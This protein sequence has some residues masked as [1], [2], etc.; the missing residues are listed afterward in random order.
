[1]QF[2]TNGRISDRTNSKIMIDIE[3]VSEFAR[4]AV[5]NSRHSEKVYINGMPWKILAQIKTK[6]ESTENNE[7]WLAIYLLYDGPKEDLNWRCCVRSATFRIVLQKNGAENS[8]G[9]I[10]DCVFNNKSTNWGFNNFI[11]FAKL[12]DP[13]N[14]F[15]NREEDKVTLIIDVI[16]K[17]SKTE[18]F[19][20][21]PNKSNGTISMEIE[22]VSEFAREVFRSERK[23]ETVHVNGMPWKIWAQIEKKD[24]STDDNDEKWLGIFL[25][26]DAPKE[27]ENWNCKCS[28]IIRIV[29]QKSD[30]SDFK[31]EF[32]DHVFD[33][34][35]NSWGYNFI[36]FSQLMDP[37]KGFYDQSE[38]KVKLAI[39]ITVKEAKKRGEIINTQYD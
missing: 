6:M 2:P 18:K 38:N 5:G 10:C 36:S 35:M 23:S 16:V 3:N 34:K 15:Y 28:V 33:Y 22:K 26:C 30:V 19:I 14:G 27:D 12:M 39:D 9:T 29:S 17:E 37:E 24:E 31:R 20:S 8:I 13:I 21:D 4:E 11:S 25:L 1:M 32:D 7:K